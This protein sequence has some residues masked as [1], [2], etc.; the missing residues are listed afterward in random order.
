MVR[1]MAKPLSNVG[2]AAIFL[3]VAA[4]GGLL[5]ITNGAL[6][7]VAA[8][9]TS[10]GTLPAG[11]LDVAALN[12]IATQ[13]SADCQVTSSAY[14]A[15]VALRN[16]RKAMRERRPV[17]V[18]AIGASSNVGA[19]PNSSASSY[20][21]QLEKSLEAFLHGIDFEVLAR[22]TTGA[23]AQDAV[24]KIK[25]EVSDLKPDLVVWQL[26]ST[27]VIG[28]FNGDETSDMVRSTLRWLKQYKVDVVL[29]DP[30]YSDR[31]AADPYY[32]KFVRTVR[33]AARAERALLVHR[34]DT[35]ADLAKR[36]SKSGAS[37]TTVV[38]DR[39]QVNNLSYRCVAEYAA[40][41]VIAG[42]LEAEKEGETPAQ[43]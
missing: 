32:V 5:A 15:R 20:S 37:S 7:Q 33:D 1:R 4:A 21:G 13:L 22:G 28:R 24:D 27:D 41:A 43:K 36:A 3:I 34:F 8:G 26:G 30:Q 23:V 11:S 10:A 6:A 39:F 14:D 16:V 31:V 40:R 18:L 35:M 38:L 25:L 42:L 19:G 2:A 9:G 12:K 17:K 29:I